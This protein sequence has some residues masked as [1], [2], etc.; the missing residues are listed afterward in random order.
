MTVHSKIQNSMHPSLLSLDRCCWNLVHRT[1]Q[2]KFVVEVIGVRVEMV[3]RFHVVVAAA[4][5]AGIDDDVR[6]LLLVVI[7]MTMIWKAV[8]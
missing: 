8:S 2:L 1:G 5:A 3:M 6:L 4:A 7:M